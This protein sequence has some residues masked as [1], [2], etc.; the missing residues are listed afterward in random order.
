MFDDDLPVIITQKDAVK[1]K[2]FNNNKIFVLETKLLGSDD[3]KDKI[4]LFATT[5]S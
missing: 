5:I 1:C 3:I 4:T 2:L